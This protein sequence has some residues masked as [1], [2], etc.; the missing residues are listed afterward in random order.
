MKAQILPTFATPIGLVQLSD[1]VCKPL[2]KLKGMEHGVSKELNFNILDKTPKIKKELTQLF[3][4]YINENILR[5]PKQEYAITSSWITENNTGA[6]MARHNH[7]NSYYS[8]VLY[9]DEVDSEHAP[10]SFESPV[11]ETGFYVEGKEPNLF[12]ASEFFVPPNKGLIIFFPSYLFHYHRKFTPTKVPR[13]SLACNYIPINQY[14]LWDS[15][16]DTRK[17]HG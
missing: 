16:L 11:N 8:S 14:G 17:L 12:N 7:K 13:R 6:S 1:E 15:S 2:K 5:T 9:F 3:S 10:L 4:G